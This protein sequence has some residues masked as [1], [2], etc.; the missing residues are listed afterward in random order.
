MKQPSA[1]SSDE[2]QDEGSKRSLK[3]FLAHIKSEYGDQKADFIWRRIGTLCVRTI[4]SIL[5]TLS[6][7]Y[8]SHFKSFSGIPVD[9]S[10]LIQAASG[11]AEDEEAKTKNESD[12]TEIDNDA[13]VPSSLSSEEKL[14]SGAS[15]INSRGSR[16]FFLLMNSCIRFYFFLIM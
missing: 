15:K 12:N 6:R 4:I 5:P 3:W 8:D 1:K 14:G 16:Y 7:E 2:I 11:L 10:S 9:I 13:S